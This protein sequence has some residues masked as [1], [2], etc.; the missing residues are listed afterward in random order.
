LSAGAAKIRL[1][2]FD[3]AGTTVDFGSR[4]PVTAF[5]RTFAAHGVELTDAEARA[6]M[7]LP[8]RDHLLALLRMPPV[9]GRWRLVHGR[10]WTDADVAGLYDRFAKEQLAVLDQHSCHVPGVL[11][12]V[13]W[14]K[15]QGIRVGATTG[16]FREAAEHVRAAAARQGFVPEHSVC[17]DDVPAG[18][19]APW[20]MYRVMEALAVYPPTAVV[21]VGDTV[22]D[23]EEGRNAGAWTVGVTGSSSEVGCSEDE[24]RRLAPGERAER[25]ARAEKKFRD[26]GAHA[27]IESLGSLP[28]IIAALN[29]R[30]R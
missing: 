5:R 22:P 18:R 17:V 2:V 16:Y 15:G 19:P 13:A 4:A 11:D 14:L 1:V 26:D 9:A 24:Y 3:W 6:P 10:E 30:G 28:A 23:I 29:E 27:I 20:M 12:C 7:G 8:K 21:K 25:L